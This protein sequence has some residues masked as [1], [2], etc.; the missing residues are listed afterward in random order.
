MDKTKLVGPF[1]QIITLDGLPLKGPIIDYELEIIS[2]GGILIEGDRIID[3][4]NFNKIRKDNTNVP[5]IE[6]SEGAVALPGFIDPH[7]HICFAGSR[8]NDYTMRIA[9]KSYLEIAKEGGGIWQTV[10]KTREASSDCLFEG[11]LGRGNQLLKS[12][13]TTAEVKSG[14]GLNLKDE[15]KMLRTIQTVD[16]ASKID[17][18]ST[19]LSAHIVPKDFNGNSTEYLTFIL[20]ELL[21]II[22]KEN[23]S[24]RVDVFIEEGAFNAQESNDYLRKAKTMGFDLTVH[25]DQFTP[26]GSLVAVETGALSVDHLE[27][28][29]EYEVQT[30]SKSDVTA[31]VLPGASIGLGMQFGPAR[32][33]LDAGCSVAIGSDWN[34]GSAPM[35]NLLSQSAILSASEKISNAE[36]FAGITFRA[37]KALNL[38]DR[39]MISNGKIADFIGFQCK[40]YREILYH[41]GQLQPNIVFKKGTKIH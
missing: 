26:S 6:I 38:H 3:V 36:T 39:G 11:T 21:P 1:A 5:I 10:Q 20:N 25:G 17:L 40:D 22:K 12:G 23:L 31:T 29:T 14:Y 30:L 7:T 4:G 32:K 9:G 27:S 34:P 16:E 35:G 15:L 18:V 13:I 19:C 2:A 8:A 24:H 28:A 41:Q 33:L 37:A